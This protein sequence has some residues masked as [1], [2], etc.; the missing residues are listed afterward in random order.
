MKRIGWIT[1]IV[2]LVLI[3]CSKEESSE[4]ESGINGTMVD[5]NGLDG[6]GFV[7]EL[8]GGERLEP[9][10]WDTFEIEQEDGKAVVFE[11]HEVEMASIC[12]VGKTIEIDCI[13]EK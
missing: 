10:N 13:T 4:C 11:Y 1:G 2:M 9:I 7:I 6:C 8:D 3:S 12:M 5:L